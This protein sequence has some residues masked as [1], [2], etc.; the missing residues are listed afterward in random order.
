MPK[1]AVS[2]LSASLLCDMLFFDFYIKMIELL[3]IYIVHVILVSRTEGT[4]VYMCTSV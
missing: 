4:P 2:D 3:Y 1:K